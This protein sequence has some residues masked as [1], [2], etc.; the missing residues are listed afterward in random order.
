MERTTTGQIALLTTPPSTRSAAPAVAEVSGLA[1]SATGAATSCGDAKRLLWL[2][3]APVL[4]G[5]R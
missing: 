2:M 5:H 4:S 1:T 3:Q